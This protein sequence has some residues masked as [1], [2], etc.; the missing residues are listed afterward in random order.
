[1]SSQFGSVPR[2]RFAPSPTGYLH[3][4]GAR[5]ALFNW[6]FARRHGGAFV[7]R[8]EDTDA[9]RS[10]AEMVTGI[11]E[12]CAGSGLD[13]DEGPDVGGPHA[14]YFQSE[15]LGA[16]PRGRRA[17]SW[18]SG[19]AYYDFG[20]PTRR[21]DAEAAD[22]GT[23]ERRYDRDACLAVPAD[24]VAR[25]L[26][27]GE[28]HA[29]RFL[30]PA[31]RDRVR[32][33][34]AR[35]RALRQR[36]HRRLRHAALGRPSHLPP[37]GGRRRHRHGDHARGAR[38]R[39]HLEHA[40][41]GA[42]L[43]R[44]RG[45]GAAVRARAA[46]HG[47][48]QEA[49]QQAPRRHVGDGIRAAGLPARGDGQLPRAARLVAGRRRRAFVKGRAGRSASRSRGSAPATRCSTPRSSTGSTTSTWAG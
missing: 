4:G 47:H 23:Y 9:E 6:L 8:I 31:G 14:P 35:R 1:M 28:P 49:A 22:D 45:A 39:P 48:R 15:R 33:P 32:R 2:V 3:V 37:V 13:W 42:A 18:P 41:A 30:V 25:R 24:E 17:T 29:I 20:G 21:G 10:S 38:R 19:R 36:P 34:G 16:L 26:A 46:D 7:L 44:V 43:R 27:A 40:Q 12:A 11:L 5:T